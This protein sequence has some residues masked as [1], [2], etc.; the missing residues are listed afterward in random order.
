MLGLRKY[1]DEEHNG[2]IKPVWTA[3][4]KAGTNEEESYFE[5][6]YQ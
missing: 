1:S 5:Q 2:D 3:Y 4:Q 6:Y